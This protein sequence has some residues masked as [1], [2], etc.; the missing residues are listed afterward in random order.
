MRSIGGLSEFSFTSAFTTRYD[1]S[2]LIHGNRLSVMQR[3]FDGHNSEQL[4]QS[5]IKAEPKFPVTN[6]P[7]SM[8]CLHAISSLL[9]KNKNKRIGAAG[10]ETFTDNPFFRPIEFEALERREL[11]PVFRPSSDKTNF[12]ATYD[13][14]ELLLEEAPLEA[15][16]RRQKPREQLKENA[17]E[18][19]IRTEELHRMI[20]TL[21]EPFNYTAISA[22]RSGTSTQH[23]HADVLTTCRDAATGE[24]AAYISTAPADVVRQAVNEKRGSTSVTTEQVQP[25]HSPA[26]TP[27]ARTR[28]STNSPSGSPQM[29][30]SPVAAGNPEPGSDMIAGPH[31]QSDA[32]YFPPNQNQ[33][34][35]K[36]TSPTDPQPPN[37]SSPPQHSST[38]YSRPI[39][40]NRIRGSTRSTSRTGGVSVV[41]DE[42]G[43]GSW[44]EM[45]ASVNDQQQQQQQQTHSKPTGMLG[46]L[47][48]KKGRDRSPRAKERERGVL[49][50]E[51]ARV[52]ISN[53]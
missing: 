19:E 38:S 45:G 12:D 27:L 20:E 8:P 4:S 3:P 26:T 49:G 33:P 36:S 34:Q 52:I 5:I 37:S 41:L 31:Y 28:A 17:T 47:S 48:R 13:L 16:A 15:R 35:G 50:K 21:F 40:S 30:A 14:E 25:S 24:E 43:T 42:R 53:T 6:P 9:E 2:P 11:E 1:L 32:E 18:R 10:F 7:V 29:S 22:E 46:F 39:P 51:G 23:T 44:N